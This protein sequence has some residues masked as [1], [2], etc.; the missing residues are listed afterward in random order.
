MSDSPRRRP[1]LLRLL[2]IIGLLVCVPLAGLCGWMVVMPGDSFEG[3]APALDEGERAVRTELERHVRM[4]GETMGE[5]HDLRPEAYARSASYIES[6][7]RDMGY[8]VDRQTFRSAG[9]REI[10][11][12]N[13]SARRIGR[14]HSDEL[15]IVGAHY[16]S[17]RGAP[18]ANDNASGVAAL[19]ALARRYADVDT[20]RTL[21]FVAFGNEE[22]PHFGDDTMGS[23]VFAREIDGAT[24]TGMISIETIG[25]YDDTPGSQR[26]P[27]PFDWFYPDRG[28]FIAFVGDLGARD[29][30]HDTITTFRRT[31]TIPSEGLAAPDVIPGVMWS[32]HRSFRGIGAPALMVT[33]TAPF[34]DNAYH[35][36]DDT[37]ARLDYERMT[38]VVSGLRAVIDDLVRGG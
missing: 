18:G 35:T 30:V 3:P 23:Y 7:W 32:D 1:R 11:A 21:V 8:R 27:S 9:K 38:R 26:Y 16:D 19:L 29:F 15:V 10:D 31:A 37:A 28:N 2:L 14:E 22:P 13:L 6:E 17:A 5:R 20:S 4:L 12:V 25:W 36:A 24:V 34:R 33:D